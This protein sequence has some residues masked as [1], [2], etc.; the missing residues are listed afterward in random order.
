ME[1]VGSGSFWPDHFILKTKICSVL[2]LYIVCKDPDFSLYFS[3][4]VLQSWLHVDSDFL[5]SSFLPSGSAAAVVA[6]ALV[7][8]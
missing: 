7:T 1:P 3:Y 6:A 5:L 2:F 4:P 8:G